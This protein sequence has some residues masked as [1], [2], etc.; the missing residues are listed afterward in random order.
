MMPLETSGLVN[1]GQLL[2]RSLDMVFHDD[3]VSFPFLEMSKM[4]AVIQ[5]VDYQS[6]KMDEGV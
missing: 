5:L 3:S 1:C 6:E 4:N 2:E